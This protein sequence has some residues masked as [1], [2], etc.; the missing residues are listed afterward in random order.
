MLAGLILIV[1]GQTI[2]FFFHC[3]LVCTIRTPAQMAH[4]GGPTSNRA[5]TANGIYR[6]QSDDSS[7]SQTVA[8]TVIATSYL[9]MSN[10]S[11]QL[12]SEGNNQPATITVN[13]LNVN[14]SQ[15]GEQP[16]LTG[17]QRTLSY[18]NAA[19]ILREQA[20]VS[21]NNRRAVLAAKRSSIVDDGNGKESADASDDT[22]VTDVDAAAA[23]SRPAPPLPP[24]RQQSNG[25][26]SPVYAS[27]ASVDFPLVETR[28]SIIHQAL[29][30]S[31]PSFP[32]PPPPPP[33]RTNTLGLLSALREQQEYSQP[34]DSTASID[35]PLTSADG[36][37]AQRN[38]KGSLNP[39]VFMSLPPRTTR[40]STASSAEV[41]ERVYNDNV[42]Q[43]DQAEAD[44]IEIVPS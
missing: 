3:C 1:S 17:Q 13:R 30:P 19:A 25:Q 4:N 16:E 5:I 31:F 37:P 28:S 39:Q 24:A 44:Y 43:V 27:I 42:N 11:D 36:L 9:P 26:L 14:E 22:A 7:T 2:Y 41:C 23:P 10:T 20:A 21:N 12:S 29:P 6:G 35:F 18:T 8:D 34:Q 32:T 40:T 38:H 33:P 15:T